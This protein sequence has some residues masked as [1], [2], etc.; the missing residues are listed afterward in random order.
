MR[1]T[2]L[3]APAGSFEIF[4]AVIAAGA[5]AVY[6]GGNAFGARAYANNFDLDD[7]KLITDYAHLRFVKIYVAMNTILF[8]HELNMAFKTVDEL[9]KI[10]IDAIIV[11]DL[12]LLHYITNN[13]SSIEA[14][15]STQF[16]I[17]DLDGIKFVESLGAKRVVLAREVNIEKIKEFKKQTKMSFET[18]IHGALCVSYSG[19]CFMSGLLGMRSGNRG[20]CVGCCRKVYTL[21]DVTNNIT[22][23]ASYLLSMKDLNVSEDIKKL[24]VVDS[25]KK[26]NIPLKDLRI[27]SQVLL[28]CIVRNNK[29]LFPDG[30]EVILPKDNIVLVTTRTGFNDLN[31]ILEG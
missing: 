19:N 21:K 18:F 26:T 13:Y 24:K 2:E 20:R 1:K 9:A 25:F 27:K 4:K 7:L 5:D 12:A 28:A 30:N 16:G 8:D 23:P 3:L 15:I 10:G 14:H 17:D 11:Q 29:V 31:D 6:V 22:Y